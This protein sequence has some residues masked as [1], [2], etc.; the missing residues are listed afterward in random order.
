M[1][2]TPKPIIEQIYAKHT[3]SEPE[4]LDLSRELG[5]TCSEINQLEQQKSAVGKDFSARIE[6]QEIKRDGLIDNVTSGY[7]MKLTNC[8]VT[9][10]PKN[11]SKDFHKQNPDGSQGEFVD[12]R[13][14]TNADFQLALPETE[15][16]AS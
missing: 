11:R 14:M 13:E 9:L 6:T 3:F 8:I 10:D 7:A 16:G 1:P 4:L 12:C 2:K 5:R 15:V